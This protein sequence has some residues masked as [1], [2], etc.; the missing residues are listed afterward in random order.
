M[1]LVPCDQCDAVFGNFLEKKIH[2]HENH[3]TVLSDV[4]RKLLKRFGVYV[5]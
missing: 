2:A 4:D 1:N 3:K 5:K